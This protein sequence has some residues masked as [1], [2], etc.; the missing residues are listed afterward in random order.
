[1]IN[2][3]YK[4]KQSGQTARLINI[5]AKGAQTMYL[6]EYSDHTTEAFSAEWFRKLWTMI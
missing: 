2:K 6:L 1:M 3:L 5:Y 4:N